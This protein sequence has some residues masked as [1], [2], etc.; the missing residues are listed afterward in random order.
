MLLVAVVAPSPAGAGGGPSS[1]PLAPAD[2]ALFGAA[3][4]PGP[5]EAPYQPVTDLEG[6]LGRR[7]AIDRYDRPFG[8]AFP[9]GREQWDIGAGRIPMISWGAVATGEVNRGSWDT[10]IRLRAR[11]IRSLGQPVLINWFADAANPNN[12]PV[13]GDAGQY[14]AA[15]R[16]I[17]RL[18]TE[19]Q[20]SNAVWV[21]CTDA[22]DFGAPTA[23]AW[24]PGD[25]SVDWTCADGYNPRNPARP[26]STAR[27]FEEIFAPF[28]DWG[29]HHD[30]PMMV[31]RYGTVEDAPGD[32]PAWVD[33]ARRSL[34]GRLSGIDAVVYDSTQAPAPTPDGAGDDWRMDSSDQSMAAFAAMGAD[35]WFKPAVEN[36]LPDTVIDSGPAKTVA[37][38]DATFAFSATG[39]GNGFECHVDRGPWQACSSPHTVTGLPDGR[40]GFEVRAIGAAGRPDPTPARWDWIVD[41]TGP[42]VTATSPKDKATNAAPGGEI[43]ATFSEAV[44]PSTVVPETFVLVTEATGEAVT[45][46]VSYDPATRKARLRPDK[47]LLP[48]AVYRA[49]VTAGV[50][51]LVGNP[52]AKDH[53]W[54]FQTTADTTPPEPPSAPQP[55]PG[56][57]QPGPAPAPPAP[58]PP[59]RHQP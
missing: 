32:K 3:V 48:L 53:E 20:A 25:D 56:A 17:R 43:T 7:L 11:A 27:S 44:D 37:S 52:M 58:A 23:D 38:H 36:T 16:R 1:A 29:S 55:G 9:D 59:G 28:H 40:H 46:K 24:Y 34:E 49:T 31:G 10:Q 18:F 45:A 51:D 54:S 33:A 21:W 35:D 4:A 19:E 5:K 2:G 47:A 8:T 6:K 30:K 41:T 14:V 50:K 39:H 15:W 42:E 13:A 22:A 26:D 57:P 12:L